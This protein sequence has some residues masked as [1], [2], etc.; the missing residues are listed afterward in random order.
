MTNSQFIYVLTITGNEDLLKE[1][2]RLFFPNLHFAFSKPGFCTFKNISRKLDLEEIAKLRLT[3]ALTVGQ[4]FK[5]ISVNDIEKEIEIISDNTE[6]NFWQLESLKL[7]SPWVPAVKLSHHRRNETI[8][9]KDYIRVS[10]DQIFIGHRYQDRW[11][12]PLLRL[13]TPIK[14]NLISRAYY[15][16]ADSFA[17]FK[18]QSNQNILELGS[19]PGGITQYLLENNHY[20]TAVDPGKMH[21]SLDNQPLLNFIKPSVQ[22]YNP[23]N[24]SNFNILVSDMNLSPKVV[25]KQCAR[26]LTK[27][28]SIS[29]IFITL[30]TNNLEVLQ[31]LP[32]YRQ[33]LKDMGCIE[34]HFIQLPKHKREFLAYGKMQQ[35]KSEKLL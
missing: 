18:I 35:R 5:M 29:D 4:S 12:S 34:T 19:V 8:T 33:M 2:V 28:P 21:E 13:F 10:D 9:Q 16:I 11:M 23:P 32:L 24:N 22:D 7:T 30:K 17:M 15:K 14:E 27:C 31:E 3:Y 26:I 1:E 6:P 20:V 25:L